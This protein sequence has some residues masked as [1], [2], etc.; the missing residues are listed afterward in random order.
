MKKYIKT[1][2]TAKRVAKNVESDLRE[3]LSI[4]TDG[5]EIT[6][7]S[8]GSGKLFWTEIF[9]YNTNSGI[10]TSAE[11][12]R[13]QEVLKSYLDEYGMLCL[14]YSFDTFPVYRDADNDFLNYPAIRVSISKSIA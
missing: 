6:S 8:H 10:L 5:P 12:E 1:E 2:R 4:F 11:I 7:R 13:T 3:G 9:V 14:Y